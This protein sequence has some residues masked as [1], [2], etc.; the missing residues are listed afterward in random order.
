VEI[1]Q[2][3]NDL[4]CSEFL[5]GDGYYSFPTI[6]RSEITIRAAHAGSA[7][8]VKPFAISGSNVTIDGIAFEGL[9]RCIEVRAPGVVIQ[10]SS[11]SQFAKAHYG[12]AIH[13]LDEGMNPANVTVIENNTFDEWGGAPNSAAVI[14]GTQQGAPYVYDSIAGQVLNN[15]FTRGPTAKQAA[16]AGNSAI[17]AFEPFLARGNYIHTVTG[18]AIQNKTKNSVISCNT[19]IE[20]RGG[21]GALYNRALGNNKWTNNVV[22]DSET[23]FDHFAG[24]NNVFSGNVFYNVAYMG[25]IKNFQSGSHNLVIENNTF[26]LSS[27]WTGLQAFTPRIEVKGQVGERD[28]NGRRR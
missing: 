7:H 9:A 5:L 4:S 23:G 28:G 17:Q 26:C 25:R 11:F 19:I 18:P 12:Y 14:L 2:Y 1:S 21:W 10:H 27:G 3:L 16:S 20:C 13:V 15:R 8:V 6:T 22:M 24:D